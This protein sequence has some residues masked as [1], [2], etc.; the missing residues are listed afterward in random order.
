MWAT[1]IELH[2]LRVSNRVTGQAADETP[3]ADNKGLLP[4]TCTGLLLSEV[5]TPLI[6]GCFAFHRR[7]P[8]SFLE[9]IQIEIRP[10]LA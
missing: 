6:Q 3:M 10:S 1:W 5:Q 4:V 2:E 8:P 7:G 9:M